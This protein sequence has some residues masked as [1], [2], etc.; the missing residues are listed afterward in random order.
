MP[1]AVVTD[2]FVYR[3]DKGVFE[4]RFV[5]EHELRM[6]RDHVPAAGMGVFADSVDEV[7]AALVTSVRSRPLESPAA[8]RSQE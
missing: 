8:A 3:S 5:A 1:Q 7:L 6:L 2:D 4:R